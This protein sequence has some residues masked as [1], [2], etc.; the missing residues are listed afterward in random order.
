MLV[1]WFRISFKEELDRLEQLQNRIRN[2]ES[3]LRQ[4]NKDVAAQEA[5]IEKL[6]DRIARQNEEIDRLE[7]KFQQERT[8]H[9]HDSRQRNHITELLDEALENCVCEIEP[10]TLSPEAPVEFPQNNVA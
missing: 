3:Q 4:A 6:N 10:E 9:Q 7:N 5:T 2:Y 8:D 1:Y